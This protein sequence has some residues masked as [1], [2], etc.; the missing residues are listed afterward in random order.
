M[1]GALEHPR[2][3]SGRRSDRGNQCVDIF[4]RM[5]RGTLLDGTEF[6]SS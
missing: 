4:W 2:G 3:T 1:A 5:I 6:D